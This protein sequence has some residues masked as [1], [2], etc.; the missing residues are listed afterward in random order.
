MTLEIQSYETD[1]VTRVIKIFNGDRNWA[2]IGKDFYFNEE[3][4]CPVHTVKI[5]YISVTP[6]FSANITLHYCGPSCAKA[7]LVTVNNFAV[8]FFAFCEIMR[9]CVRLS[10]ALLKS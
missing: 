1:F 6:Q 4:T 9:M 5:R 2:I 3:Y 8:A 10:V 7:V